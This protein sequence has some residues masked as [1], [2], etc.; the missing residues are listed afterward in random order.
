MKE[1]ITFIL[2]QTNA[3]IKAENDTGKKVFSKV[4]ILQNGNRI[5]H[6]FSSNEVE[7]NDIQVCGVTEYFTFS[8]CKIFKNHE[9]IRLSFNKKMGNSTGSLNEFFKKLGIRRITYEQ[10]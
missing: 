9:G 10:K 4:V 5:G 3:D 1:N 6:I 2:E 8:G 7:N